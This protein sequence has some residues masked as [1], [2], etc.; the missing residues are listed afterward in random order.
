M[1]SYGLLDAYAKKILKYSTPVGNAW[2]TIN[3]I[4][5][6]FVVAIIGGGIY[7]DEQGAFRCDTNQPGCAQ[8]CF[9]R[10]SPMSHPRFWA[11]QMVCVVIPSVIFIFITQNT[12]AQIKKLDSMD[13]EMKAKIDLEQDEEK[14]KNYYS[15]KEYMRLEKKKS[16]IGPIKTKKT[17]DQQQLVEVIWTPRIRIW[18]VIQCIMKFFLEIIF[19]FLYY[20]LQKQQS[21]KDGFAAWMVPEKY[22]CTYGADIDNFAC[23]QNSEIPCWVSRPYEKMVMM[24]YMLTVSALSGILCLVECLWVTTR[25]SVK[26]NK[27]KKE[28]RQQKAGLLSNMHSPQPEAP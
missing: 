17:T 25:I 7:G 11:F 13:K 26:A 22:V 28:R 27:R 2:W 20:I 1:I 10:F 4:F 18:Y 16:K 12:E 15:S 8:M 3:F 21:K 23:S 19:I 6:M 9:N 5:R 14:Q 24:W